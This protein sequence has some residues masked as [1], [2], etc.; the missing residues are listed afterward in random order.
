MMSTRSTMPELMAALQTLRI[1]K[2]AF[3]D[4]PEDDRNTAN[5]IKSAQWV[6]TA[7]QNTR[8]HVFSVAYHQLLDDRSPFDV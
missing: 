3:F 1:D 7:A 4:R 2:A 5:L 6:L 8:W